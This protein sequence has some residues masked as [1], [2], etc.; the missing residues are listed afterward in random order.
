MAFPFYG[1][2]NSLMASISVPFT[3]FALPCLIYNYVYRNKERRDNAPLLP[4]KWLTV[5]GGL[6]R[7]SWW[8]ITKG[9]VAKRG[10]IA[11]QEAADA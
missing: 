6:G 5:S 4:W 8:P 1:A 11:E 2:I 3:A 9:P 10:R 7:G